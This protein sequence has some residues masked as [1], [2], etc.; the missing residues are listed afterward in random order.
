MTSL[1]SFSLYFHL[2]FEQQ[3]NTHQPFLVFLFLFLIPFLCYLFFLFILFLFLIAF[4]PFFHFSFSCSSCPAAIF[5][6]SF[7]LMLVLI[8]LLFL[9]LVS[10][11]SIIHFLALIS[12]FPCSLFALFIRF[13]L[14]LSF[15]FVSSSQNTIICF[16]SSYPCRSYCFIFVICVPRNPIVFFH[17]SHILFLCVLFI[18]FS[19]FLSLLICI[20]HIT[21]TYLHSFLSLSLVLCLVHIALVLIHL[22]H[23]SN[24]LHPIICILTFI[25]GSLSPS[26]N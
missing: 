13:F 6:F 1:S 18:S 12:P 25:C 23:L 14:Q 26:F 3:H 19:L 20:S 16:A 7:F 9:A 8:H 10:H 15:F 5:P 4:F 11:S 2:R 21:I 17:L 22:L 24:S